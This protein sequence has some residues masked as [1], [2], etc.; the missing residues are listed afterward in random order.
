MSPSTEQA[1]AHAPGPDGAARPLRAAWHQHA[2]TWLRWHGAKAAAA[3]GL[4]ALLALA[5]W[6]AAATLQAIVLPHWQAEAQR[7]AASTDALQRETARLRATPAAPSASERL[8]Q[9]VQALPPPTTASQLEALARLHDGA[10]AAQ[11]DWA[12]ASVR[13]AQEEGTPIARLDIVVQARG[14]YPQLRGFAVRM[15]QADRALALTTLRL[16]RPGTGDT[17]LDAEFGFTLFMRA[18]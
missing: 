10:R 5:L 6:L 9:V 3:L 1:H 17:A 14:S 2:V 18:P 11:L 15:L 16:S 4:P 7:L 13:L 8:R 12:G